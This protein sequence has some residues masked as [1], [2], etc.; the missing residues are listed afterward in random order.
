M[1]STMWI[2]LLGTFLVAVMSPGPDF[3]IVLRMSL[4]SG[5]RVGR[6]AA[7]GIATGTILWIIATMVGIVA[8]INSHPTASFIIRLVGAGFLT[9]YGAQILLA[10]VRSASETRE[11]IDSAISTH[12][13]PGRA[14]R[15]GFLTTTVGNPKAVVFYTAFF[16]TMLPP[17]MGVFDSLLLGVCMVLISFSWFAIVATVA[18]NETFIRGYQRL[19]R[20]I[21]VLLG[22]LFVILGIGLFPWG[23]FF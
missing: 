9:V 1:T 19:H 6:M 10:T 22:V 16:A 4:S 15:L 14:F 17:G 7:S 12:H 23:R 11:S 21:D 18:A 8:L 13:S 3:L 20:P 5:R 2:A